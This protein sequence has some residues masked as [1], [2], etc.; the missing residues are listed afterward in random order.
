MEGDV[1][2][3]VALGVTVI[4]VAAEN[5]H[6]NYIRELILGGANPDVTNQDDSTTVLV[7]ALCLLQHNMG[8][9]RPYQPC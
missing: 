7:A 1:D 8:R 6:G 5:G 4:F 9:R 3:S 2:A